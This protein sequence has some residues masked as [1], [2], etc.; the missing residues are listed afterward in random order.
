MQVLA[1]GTCTGWKSS[2]NKTKSG[3]DNFLGY[4]YVSGFL[5]SKF[6]ISKHDYYVHDQLMFSHILLL[7]D[8]E[9]FQKWDQTLPLDTR[10]RFNVYKTSIRRSDVL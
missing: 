6:Y 2:K 1:K 10:R 8:N 7:I 3:F 9:G 4:A 5:H